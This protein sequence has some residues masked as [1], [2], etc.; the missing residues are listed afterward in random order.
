MNLKRLL[1]LLLAALCLVG[2]LPLTAL[3]ATNYNNAQNWRTQSEKENI[4][5]VVMAPTP[6]AGGGQQR[7]AGLLH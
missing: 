4:A 5:N 2:L 7:H 6:R 1:C 3:A